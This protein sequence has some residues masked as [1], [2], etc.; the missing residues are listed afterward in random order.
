MAKLKKSTKK[1]NQRKLKGELERRKKVSKLQ[2]PRKALRK[3]SSRA[4]LD[5]SKSDIEPKN[6]IQEHKMEL[7]KLKA[8][9]PEFYKFLEENDSDLLD[10][11]LDHEQPGEDISPDDGIEVMLESDEDES[12]DM[13]I[14]SSENLTL[15]SINSWKEE[16]VGNRSVKAMKE[17][18]STFK[19]AME[20]EENENSILLSDGQALNELVELLVKNIPDLLG[21]FLGLPKVIPRNFKIS[22][23]KQQWKKYSSI[24][25]SF[26]ICI[27]LILSHVD[28]T[29]TQTLI[30]FELDSSKSMVIFGALGVTKKSKKLLKTIL[31]IATTVNNGR[32]DAEEDEVIADDRELRTAA[33]IALKQWTMHGTEEFKELALKQLYQSF[34]SVSRSTNVY[35][36]PSISFLS[37]SIS[38]IFSALPK[39]SYKLA[40]VSIRRIAMLLRNAIVKPSPETNQAILN[41]SVIHSLKFWLEFLHLTSSSEHSTGQINKYLRQLYFPCIQV[42]LGVLRLAPMKSFAPIHLHILEGL[43]PLASPNSFQLPTAI[44]TISVFYHLVSTIF[45]GLQRNTNQKTGVK[46]MSLPVTLKISDSYPCTPNHYMPMIEKCLELLELE[47]KSWS[48]FVGFPEWSI[49]L[50]IHMKRLKKLVD[51]GYISKKSSKNVKSRGDFDNLKKKLQNIIKE[52]S[53]NSEWIKQGRSKLDYGPMDA[54]GDNRM[55]ILIESDSP[56]QK[57]FK[58]RI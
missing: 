36:L 45:T 43:V 50:L 42:S 24:V 10:F 27:D 20:A 22:P 7:E 18:I 46:P 34:L 57:A 19:N 55:E 38:E 5:E 29:K 16:I 15:N 1:F 12:D 14:D 37:H 8:Q 23:E 32:D 30:L 28:S 25:K 53:E 47:C 26:M 52:V 2:K 3:D 35:T 21:S 40:F 9:D 31:A 17:A 49:G 48:H 51:K 13:N 33:M 54:L 58:S 6:D 4:K 41:W 44:Q 39:L 11:G 56:L